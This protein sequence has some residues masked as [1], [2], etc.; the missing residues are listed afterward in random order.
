MVETCS[1][2]TCYALIKLRVHTMYKITKTPN[3]RTSKV[4]KIIEINI[5][6]KPEEAMLCPG[7][8]L[9]STWKILCSRKKF[10]LFFSLYIKITSCS[11]TIFL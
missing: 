7:K 9:S 8:S 4:L 5:F 11:E 2:P 3:T 10:E 1:A 6:L